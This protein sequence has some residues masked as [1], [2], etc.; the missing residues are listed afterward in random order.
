[1]QCF[2]FLGVVIILRGLISVNTVAKPFT[3]AHFFSFMREF[4]L[5]RSPISAG[6]VKKPSDGVPISTDIRENT[7]CTSGISIVK[8]KRL[9]IYSQKFS[10]IRS[11]FGVKNVEKPLHVKEAF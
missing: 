7:F 8:V 11:P 9:Q 10:L 3:I 5:E 4:T 6:S 1:V 2:P